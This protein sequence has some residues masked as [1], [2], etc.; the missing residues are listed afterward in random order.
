MEANGWLR[1]LDYGRAASPGD[2]LQ[3]S[4]N[5]KSGS[6]LELLDAYSRAVVQVVERVGPAV[7]AIRMRR[8]R[9][10][11]QAAE[12]AGSGVII[13]PDGFILT[14]D[15]VV[16]E[17]AE[18]SV[19]FTT[20]KTA[21]ARLVGA[22]PATDLAV[23]QAATSDLPVAEL[24]N[25]DALR[26]GQMAIAIGNP[27]GFQSTVSAG[28][29]SALG[30]TLRS[31]SGRLIENVIQTDVALNPGNSGGP[32]VDS[33]GRVIGINTAMIF[34]AQG[35]SFAIPVNTAKWV[36]GELIAHGRVRRSYLGISAGVQ[37][38][39]P[40]LQR[41][42]G[43]D[44]QTVVEVVEVMG[45]G[46]AERA[47]LRP[48][49]LILSLDGEPIRTVDDIH[50]LLTRWRPGHPAKMDILHASRKHTIEIVPQESR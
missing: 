35:I 36:A 28:V 6:D 27:L 14:N 33:H 8:R 26:V 17:A 47:G 2:D 31:R 23:I 32:L 10:I 44:S 39:S 46:P 5:G 13:A 29:V 18:V 3:P 30:R 21:S 38:I 4:S 50:R 7:A 42:L 40:Y 1:F 11:P 25:S 24:G 43:V 15:H 12:G 19:T 16:D 20:G 48:G 41:Q 49:D 22:D 37:P 34:M 9:G 45:G